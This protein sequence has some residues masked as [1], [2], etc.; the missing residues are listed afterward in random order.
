ME[1]DMTGATLRSV[2]NGVQQVEWANRC[3]I[4]FYPESIRMGYKSEQAGRDVFEDK[5]FIRIQFP[6]DKTKEVCRAATEDDQRQFHNQWLQYKSS[7]EQTP[8]GMPLSQWPLCGKSDIRNLAQSGV[9]TV[10]QLAVLS[11][12]QLQGV[13]AGYLALREKARA[14]LEAAKNAE[15]L[16]KIMAKVEK[17]EADNLALSNQ[18][19]ALSTKK[20]KDNAK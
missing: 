17:L 2:G 16:A 20:E 12:T 5:D 7:Q 19:A 15:P 11:D 4:E 9:K 8:D 6:G 14:W 18:L 13:G 3:Y 10:E 1:M